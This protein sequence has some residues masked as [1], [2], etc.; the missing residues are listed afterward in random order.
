[1]MAAAA[2]LPHPEA[3]V[4]AE[5]QISG[6]GSEG[7]LPNQT[8]AQQGERVFLNVRAVFEQT[9]GDDVAEHRVAQKLQTLIVITG[10][11]FVRKCLNEKGGIVEA[12]SEHDLQARVR[13]CA[14]CTRISCGR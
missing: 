12:V 3:Q 5:T 6:H 9:M 10:K 7:F 4:A 14:T 11:A 1:M 8:G 13:R 2:A